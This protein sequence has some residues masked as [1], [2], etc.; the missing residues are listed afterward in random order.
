LVGS[1]LKLSR[2]PIWLSYFVSEPQISSRFLS[3]LCAALTVSG[4]VFGIALI[5]FAVFAAMKGLRRPPSAS[6]R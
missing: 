2:L 4:F 1:W 3:L 6:N 5:G